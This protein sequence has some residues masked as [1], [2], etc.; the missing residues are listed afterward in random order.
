MG[1]FYTNVT[2]K[3]PDQLAIIR[4][5]NGVRRVALVADRQANLTV[6]FDRRSE[7]QD[8]AAYPFLEQ[9]TRELSC[10]ALYVT[11]HDDSVL[12][13]RLY[14]SGEILDNYDSC[15]GYFGEGSETPEGGDAS[16]LCDA[17]EIPAARDMVHEILHYDRRAVENE[18][19][20]RY[21][22]EVGRH[23]DLATAL[24]LPLFAVGGG[25]TYLAEDEWP[26]G[27]SPENIVSLTGGAVESSSVFVG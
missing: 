6:V 24:R 25:Y 8:S 22:W 11:N 19:S 3:G 26:E 27:L 20:G 14:R 21:V 10:L 18:S 4:A 13:Y 1:H 15:P 2:L 17:F 5:L 12:Y 23:R 16:V 7:A 9:L